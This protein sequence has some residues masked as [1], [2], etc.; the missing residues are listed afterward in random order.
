MGNYVFE[1]KSTFDRAT[2]DR[3]WH[4]NILAPHTEQYIDMELRV[5]ERGSNTTRFFPY[6]I[7]SGIRG[8][9]RLYS[10]TL[11]DGGDTP[12]DG[13]GEDLILFCTLTFP[14]DK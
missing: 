5:T 2:G 7:K 8:A 11:K 10:F 4:A 14:V 9:E 3:D 12:F 1:G 6:S 13:T